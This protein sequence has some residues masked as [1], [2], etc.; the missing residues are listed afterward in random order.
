MID[1]YLERFYTLAALAF[2][3]VSAWVMLRPHV[4]H[5]HC[6]KTDGYC[7]THGKAL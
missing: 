3:A 1:K 2:L 6:N 4:G 5:S 7:F